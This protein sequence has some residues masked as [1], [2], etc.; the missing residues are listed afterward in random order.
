MKIAVDAMGG[1]YAPEEIVK[2]AVLALEERELEIILLGSMENI[3]EEL[4]KYKYEKNNISIV[5]CKESIETSDFPL[6]AIRSKK[7]S[8]IVVG[9]K[10]LKSDEA[11]AFISA[12]NSGAVMAAAILELGCV[13]QIRRPSVGAILPSVKGKVLVLDVGANVD[14]KPEHLLQFAHLGSKYAKHIL[15]MEDPKIG[16]LNIGEE[17]NKGNKFS[18]DAYKILKNSNINFVG[19][20]E[21]K[22]IFKGKVDVAVCDGF[23]GNILL[24]CSEGLAK[25]LLTEINQMVISQLPQ[26]QEMDKLKENFMNLVKIT[27]Y[28]EQGG[29]PLLGISGLC[30]ICHGRSKAKTFKNAILNTGK[31]VDSNIIEHFKE[32]KIE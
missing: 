18:Q 5:N 6:S 23:I 1:D 16:L 25:L 7:D 30:F 14:C 13:S 27:D 11:D 4:A 20:I 2:G 26:N 24:K 15:K 19:N 10:L 22:D 3:K 28:T 12:G 17:E 29:S 8:S 32:I 21:G 9:M 31:F